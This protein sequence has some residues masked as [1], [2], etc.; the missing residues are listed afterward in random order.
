MVQELRSQAVALSGVMP[1]AIGHGVALVQNWTL[2]IGSALAG[3]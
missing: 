2:V 1:C 3:P